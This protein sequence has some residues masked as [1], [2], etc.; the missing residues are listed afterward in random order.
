MDNKTNHL[1]MIQDIVNRLAKCSFL[2]KGWAVIL[3]S[4]LFALAAK[5]SRIYF[6][7]LAYFPALAFW[8]LDGYYLW[9]E[10]LYRKLYD[11]VRVMDDSEVNFSMDTT[12]VTDQVDPW[13]SVI[14]SKT[15]LIFHGTIVATIL[16][17]ML[18][19]I[20]GTQ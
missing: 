8:G 20:A 4:A 14:F 12:P 13:L 17:V 3:V 5:D 18:I 10:R 7:Y 11:K 19:V 15:I 2:L 9:Q 6:I 16:I 1:E